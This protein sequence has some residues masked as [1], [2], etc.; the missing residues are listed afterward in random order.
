ML[1]LILCSILGICIGFII[2]IIFGSIIF[3]FM[4]LSNKGGWVDEI[5][6]T[7]ENSKE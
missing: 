3:V 4:V 5:Y 2:F 7:A 1:D 6:F